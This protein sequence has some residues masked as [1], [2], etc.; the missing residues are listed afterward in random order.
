[1]LRNFDDILK[2]AEAKPTQRF[3]V[4]GA[5]TKTVLSAVQEAVRLKLMN[6]VLIGRMKII[7]MLTEEMRFSIRDL[8]I[9]DC[10]EPDEVADTAVSLLDR[11]D[12]DIL[13]KGNT[14]TPTLLKAVLNKKYSLR[15]K[16]LLT[17]I[18]L[19]EIPAYHKLLLI[20]DGGMVIRPNL[21]QKADI[22]RNAVHM[23]KQIGIHEPRVA[24]LAASEKI[25]PKM[26]ETE[27]AAN[28]AAMADQGELGQCV[29]EGPL[30]MDIAMSTRSA[31]IKAVKSIVSG[32]PDILL[33][34]DIACGNILAKGLI[35]LAGAG[36]AGLILGA[37][38]PVVLLSRA[39][40][41]ET[42]LNSIALAAVLS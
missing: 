32:N 2:T 25:N 20:T 26:P 34:P 15:P 40:S 18:A 14:D 28:L 19:M 7:Q 9:V 4:A 42:R 13:M 36:I 39:D 33:V 17:H 16:G 8:K 21:E 1:M 38:R 30:A 27:D 37:R 35:Y 24:V 11:G 5:D 10:Y 22:I 6:P 31:E 3:A 41:I 29:V 23:M 12:A